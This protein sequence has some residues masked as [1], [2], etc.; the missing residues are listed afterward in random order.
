MTDGIRWSAILTG[1]EDSTTDLDLRVKSLSM[2]LRE[3]TY[4]FVSLVIDP[5][6]IDDVLARPNG[7]IDIYRTELPNG[8]PELIVSTNQQESRSDYGAN[9]QS[10]TLTGTTSVSFTP[11][12]TVDLYRSSV[13]TDRKLDSGLKSWD[14]SPLLNII[15]GD[16]VDYYADGDSLPATSYEIDLVTILANADGTQ[17]TIREAAA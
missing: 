17:M 7:T 4:S 11:F 9:N 10:V 12:S 5:S 6:Q 2:S 3:S 14:V 15:P 1:T 16:T 13:V 8:S